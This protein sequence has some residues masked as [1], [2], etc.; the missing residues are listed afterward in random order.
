[1]SDRR[2]G[3]VVEASATGRAIVDAIRADNPG[4][5]IEVLDRAAYLRVLVADRCRVSRGAIE[6]ALGRGFRLPG[7]LELVMPSWKGALAITADEVV[8]EAR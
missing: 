3:P 1:M 5:A 7:D 2:V 8:W 6:A 4:V